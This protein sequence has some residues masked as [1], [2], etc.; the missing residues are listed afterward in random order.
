DG[1]LTGAER[2]FVHE[3][4]QTLLEFQHDLARWRPPRPSPL[5]SKEATPIVS[6]YV[7]GELRGCQAYGAGPSDQRLARAFLAASADSRFAAFEQHERAR[8]VAQ[9]SYARSLRR[10]TAKDPS[11]EFVAG[12]HGL[13][14]MVDA[15]PVLLV[16]DVARDL[17]LDEEGFLSVLEQKSNLSRR[18][19]PNFAL[20][21]FETE[22]IVARSE[23]PLSRD[24][25]L[26]AALNW[27][28]RQVESNGE[29]RFGFDSRSGTALQRGPL[30][31]ARAASVIQVLALDPTTES[32]AAR[33]RSW[34]GREL[35]RAHSGHGV[36]DWPDDVAA[37]A[38]TWAL[39][40]LAGV[41][42]QATLRSLASSAGLHAEPWHAAQVVA[43]LGREAPNEL[44]QTCVQSLDS[45]PFAPWTA[46]AAHRRDDRAT[47]ERAIGHLLEHLPSPEFGFVSE[48]ALAGLTLEA[49][50]LSENAEVRSR[51]ANAFELLHRCQLWAD[52]DP[53]AV[54]AWVHGAFPL[55]P[56]QT[57]LRCDA[58]AHAALALASNRT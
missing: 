48:P 3:E 45:Q 51:R 27:L 29:V 33:A 5:R 46:I 8:I 37:V 7:L 23:P 12:I 57:L 55:A 21:A 15:H 34:L 56:S 20:Y 16:P 24:E 44:W 18:Q 47:F 40:C 1:P 6:L 35:E 2:S 28:A 4:L 58:S 36:E 52:C 38:A 50:G 22:R 43:A 17:G 42:A 9:A 31:H 19:W 39:A 54:P 41:R 49:L 10:I 30:R 25:P 11:A 14:L 26:P 53:A 13:V 32:T